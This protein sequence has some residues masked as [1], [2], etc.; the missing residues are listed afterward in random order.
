MALCPVHSRLMVFVH[1]MYFCPVKGCKESLTL[2][3][4]RES[5]GKY[6]QNL[7]PVAGGF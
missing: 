1:G 7:N 4:E 6:D 2:D 3:Q 5:R